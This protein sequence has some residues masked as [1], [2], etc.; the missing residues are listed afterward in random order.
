MLGTPVWLQLVKG[1]YGA[2]EVDVSQGDDE[3][4]FIC[5]GGQ[6]REGRV[7]LKEVA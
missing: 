5:L 4:G 3:T 7:D 6:D 2:V 1:P